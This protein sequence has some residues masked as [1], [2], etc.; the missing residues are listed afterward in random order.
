[1]NAQERRHA[2]VVAMEAAHEFIE[3]A[4]KALKSDEDPAYTKEN[5][6]LKA[7]ALILRARLV[8]VRK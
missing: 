4:D 5:G 6:L 2:I 7:Q 3:L 1:M 8:K